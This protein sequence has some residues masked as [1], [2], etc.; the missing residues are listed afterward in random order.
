MKTSLAALALATLTFH[1]LGC[2]PSDKNS[3]AKPRPGT[4]AT[5][6]SSE[7]KSC[8]FA[9]GKLGTCVAKIDCDATKGS[10]F[11]CQSQH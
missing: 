11:T 9:P 7:G 5:V 10:C 8:E 4:P 2:P 3:D 6:C 1:T